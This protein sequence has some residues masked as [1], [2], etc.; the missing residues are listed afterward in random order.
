MKIVNLKKN[1]VNNNLEKILIK[2][3]NTVS[4]RIARIVKD[5]IVTYMDM[6]LND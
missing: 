4:T 1:I 6:L 5:I 2:R 3:N